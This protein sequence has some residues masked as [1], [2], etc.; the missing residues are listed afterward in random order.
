MSVS[1]HSTKE[2]CFAHW[3]MASILLYIH[4]CQGES[5]SKMANGEGRKKKDVDCWLRHDTMNGLSEFT[6]SDPV[7]NP[8]PQR[9]C[10]HALRG[11][12]PSC[13]TEAEF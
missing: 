1:V 8:S 13:V 12:A 5:K 6:S 11:M 2:P 7:T 9:S 10:S 3:S 4:I